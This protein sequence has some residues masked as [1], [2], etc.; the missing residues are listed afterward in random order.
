MAHLP[1][2]FNSS[3]LYTGKTMVKRLTHIGNSLGLV[4]EK[5][6]LELL[7]ISA[8]TELEMTTDGKRLLIEPIC[9]ISEQN[10]TGHPSKMSDAPSLGLAQA[11]ARDIGPIEKA[12]RAHGQNQN[13]VTPDRHKPFSVRIRSDGILLELG[14]KQYPTI[15][16]WNWLE[17]VVEF[18]RARPSVRVGGVN[19]T[20]GEPGTLDG[21]FKDYTKVRVSNYV[22]ALLEQAGV[23][24]ILLKPLR[25]Q[26]ARD[27][28]QL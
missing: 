14:K 3:L 15:L 24:A 11:P 25:V 17:N 5:P 27:Y 6:I 2:Q 20:S 19:S 13:L 16:R 10:A 7:G 1:Q 28:K 9:S 12:I 18:L 22:A 21:Y 26:L 23:V 4:I 8:E